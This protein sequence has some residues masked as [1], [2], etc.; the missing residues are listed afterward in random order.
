MWLIA[1]GGALWAFTAF[2]VY[3]FLY[4]G[5]LQDDLDEIH[6]HQRQSEARK[7][8]D[9]IDMKSDNL[10]STFETIIN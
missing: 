6:Y 8:E 1:I 9:S 10:P 7:I 2:A 5:G 4:I 3:L